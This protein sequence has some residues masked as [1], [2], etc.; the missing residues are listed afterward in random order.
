[1]KVLLEHSGYRVTAQEA[2]P[3]SPDAT[4]QW[5]L[6]IE[7]RYTRSGWMPIVSYGTHFGPIDGDFMT[8]YGSELVEALDNEMQFQGDRPRVRWTIHDFI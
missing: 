6:M 2:E 3:D 8:S 1:M 5:E 7:A 4:E